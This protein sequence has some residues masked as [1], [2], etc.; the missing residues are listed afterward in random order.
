[1][2]SEELNSY[3][4]LNRDLKTV[5]REQW[6]GKRRRRLRRKINV[7]VHSELMTIRMSRRDRGGEAG[8]GEADQKYLCLL[9]LRT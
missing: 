4:E 8:W 1:M 6:V 7:T 2:L 5:A 9:N 3:V